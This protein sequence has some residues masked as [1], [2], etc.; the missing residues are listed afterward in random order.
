MKK[1]LIIGLAALVAATAS[2]QEEAADSLGLLDN[3]M[4]QLEK[5]SKLIPQISGAV[6]GGYS[7]TNYE[8]DAVEDENTFYF[9][10]IRLMVK[11][12]PC[13]WVGYKVQVE[14]WRTPALLD[15][16]IDIHPLAT[17]KA[18]SQ[19]LNFW[20]GQGKLPL[21]IETTYGPQTA[22][23]VDYTPVLLALAGYNSKLTPELTSVSG[24]RDVGAAIYGYAGRVNWGGKAHDL[25]EYKLGVYNGSGRHV[26]DRDKYKDL[27]G[28]LYLHPVKEL[29]VGGSLYWGAYKDA[30]GVKQERRRWAA[31]LRYENPHWHARAEYI[32]GSTHGVKTDGW[33]GLLQYT[34]NPA[35][36][37]MKVWNQW[38]VMA[39][40]DGYRADVA[41][42]NI[43]HRA[44]LGVNYRPLKWLYLQAY[45]IYH[46]EESANKHNAAVTMCAIF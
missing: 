30:S 5:K 18:K 27:C 9:K 6:K 17:T 13:P 25:V 20:L 4:Q 36:A 38:A 42:G 10:S 35:T 3:V 22:I 43:V 26:V 45:Y 28:N 46:I 32:G 15:A 44:Q 41:A 33:Y 31:S 29:T 12:A 37:D 11:G 7:Y 1:L 24:G 2:A 40:Y 14:W 34:I 21:S 8:N 16:A 23:A 39:M 19:Y